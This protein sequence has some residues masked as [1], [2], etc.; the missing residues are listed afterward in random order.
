MYTD[1]DMLEE[2]DVLKQ[3]QCKGLPFDDHNI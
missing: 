3:V 2:V 1:S